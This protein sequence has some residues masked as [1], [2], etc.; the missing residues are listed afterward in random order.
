MPLECAIFAK[1]E[2]EMLSPPSGM[3]SNVSLNIRKAFVSDTEESAVP[4]ISRNSLKVKTP[5]WFASPAL[6]RVSNDALY[7]QTQSQK[8]K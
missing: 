3:S 1:A 8:L 5:S 2:G 7:N 6:N 4:I